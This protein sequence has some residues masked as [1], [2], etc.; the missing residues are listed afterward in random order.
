MKKGLELLNKKKDYTTEANKFLKINDLP[1]LFRCFLNLYDIGYEMLNVDK[2]KVKEKEVLSFIKVEM[3]NNYPLNNEKYNATI[4]L[5][6]GFLQLIVEFNKYKEKEDHWHDMGFMKIGLMFHGDVLLLGMV[7][8]NKDEI[9]RYGNG[10]LDTVSCKLDDNIFSFFTRLNQ[11]VDL[12]VLEDLEVNSSQLYKNWG[13]DFWR[14]RTE[15][16]PS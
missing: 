6:F 5:V 4:D 8:S 7:E 13:E 2:L 15:K 11:N 9:W 10:L 14:V 1:P 16:E 3:F 12:E